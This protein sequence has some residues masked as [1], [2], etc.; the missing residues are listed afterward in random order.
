MSTVEGCEIMPLSPG[1][2]ILFIICTV[3]VL[4]GAYYVTYYIGTKMA[5]QNSRAGI[6]NR[7]IT[8]LDRYAVARDKS[9]CVVEIAGKVYIVGVTNHNMTLLDT[10]DAANFAK[11]IKENENNSSTTPWHLTPVGRYGNKLTRK[12][13]DYIA[14]KTGKKPGSD[15]YSDETEFSQTLKEAEHKAKMTED[16]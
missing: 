6:R 12:V 5:G 11:S 13:V 3:I 16:D 4:F 10:I 2:V 1:Q 15:P 8:L 9:L 7:N 14:V